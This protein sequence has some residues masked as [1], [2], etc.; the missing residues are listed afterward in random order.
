MVWKPLLVA[1]VG[2]WYK[3]C[4]ICSQ[5]RVFGP[6]SVRFIAG[7]PCW[8]P[9]PKALYAR[10]WVLT[11]KCWSPTCVWGWDNHPMGWGGWWGRGGLTC[12]RVAQCR[13]FGPYSVRFIAGHPC[14]P[15]IP[16]A[17]YA[18]WWVLTHKCGSPTCLWGWGNHPMGWGG[19]WGRGGLTC[20]RVAQFQAK[21][22]KSGILAP[23]SE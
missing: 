12:P 16:K 10:W 9:I 21:T 7:H 6:Y 14:W 15:P 8:P 23:G 13:L 17:L 1:M 3:N 18:R 4:E 11:H 20:P 22:N 19:R 2:I 5:F